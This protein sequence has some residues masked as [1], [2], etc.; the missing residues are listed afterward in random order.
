MSKHFATA[1]RK[2]SLITGRN[3][4]VD[5]GLR[6]V[7]LVLGEGTRGEKDGETKTKNK[8]WFPKI[9]ATRFASKFHSPP[10][11]FFD[12]LKK[13]C[14]CNLVMSPKPSAADSTCQCLSKMSTHPMTHQ[15][16]SMLLHQLRSPAFC[17]C[18]I[19]VLIRCFYCLMCAAKIA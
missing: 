2:T 4:L 9:K 14:L 7:R 11:T 3:P 5:H 8:L 10:P 15:I 13:K 17:Y 18:G 1:G 16:P 6:R 12:L 19:N